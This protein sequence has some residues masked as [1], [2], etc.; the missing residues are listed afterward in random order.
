MRD[1][2]NRRRADCDFGG[3]SRKHKERGNHRNQP[4]FGPMGRMK[5]KSLPE[6]DNV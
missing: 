3:E 1:K 4:D 6:Y 2:W 5:L